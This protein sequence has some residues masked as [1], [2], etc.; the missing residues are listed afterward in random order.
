MFSPRNREEHRRGAYDSRGTKVVI[1]FCMGR[2]TALFSRGFCFNYANF[3]IA[4]SV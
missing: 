1:C 3:N 2:F 4:S